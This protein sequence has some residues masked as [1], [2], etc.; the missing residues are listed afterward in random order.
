LRKEH[1]LKV[2]ENRLLRKISGPKRDDVTEE[3]R[4]RHNEVLNVLH[5][6][7]N[8]IRVNKSRS[9]KRTGHVAH[10]GGRRGAYRTL[11][12]KPEGKSPLEKPRRRCEDNIKLD[13]QKVGWRGGR[14]IDP[15][16]DRDRWWTLVKAVTNL[17]VP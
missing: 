11:V 1:R 9:K 7:P 15:A 10:M 12:R 3:W 14:L 6:P 17:L 4:K 2:F 16:Q 8:I 5:S 13:L